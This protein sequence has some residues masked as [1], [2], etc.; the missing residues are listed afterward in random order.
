MEKVSKKS[1]KKSKKIDKSMINW[2]I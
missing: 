1:E 2:Y